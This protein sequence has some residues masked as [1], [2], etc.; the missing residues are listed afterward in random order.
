M[1]C[2]KVQKSSEKINGMLGKVH[3]A[4]KAYKTMKCIHENS[5]CKGKSKRID[6]LQRL[7]EENLTGKGA[8]KL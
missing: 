1:K 6:L 7:N 2:K 4:K 3:M 8:M 5:N